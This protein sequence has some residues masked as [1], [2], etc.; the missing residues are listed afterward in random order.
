MSQVKKPFL[1]LEIPYC[2]QNKMASKRFMKNFHQLTGE[3]Y[4]I[5]VKWLMKKLKINFSIKRL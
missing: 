3:T 2:G 4:N 5:A 1:L